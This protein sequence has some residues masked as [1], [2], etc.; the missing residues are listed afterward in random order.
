MECTFE[1]EQVE[2]KQLVYYCDV[3]AFNS[4]DKLV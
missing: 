4:I 1:T 2:L 3:N